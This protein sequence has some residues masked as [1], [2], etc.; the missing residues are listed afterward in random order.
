VL[1]KGIC[2]IFKDQPAHLKG[3][4]LHV[5]TSWASLQQVK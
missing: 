2:E 1:T 5:S 4:S 3:Y